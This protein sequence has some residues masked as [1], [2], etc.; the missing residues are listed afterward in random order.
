MDIE[1]ARHNMVEQQI[2]PW[3]V[4]DDKVLKSLIHVKR[5]LFVG[6]D[7]QGMAFADIE[8]PLPNGQHMLTPKT[9]A[10]MIVGLNIQPTDKV[11]E[12]GTGSGYV[13]ALLGRL[14]HHVYSVEIDPEQKTRAAANLQ[15]AH[16]THNV[17]LLE[18]DGLQG[19]LAQ[20]PYQAIFVGGS[21]PAVPGALRQ[22]LAIGGRMVVIVGDQPV[23]RV[24]L[25]ERQG[26]SAFTETELFDTCAERLI[27]AEAL[28]NPHFE[29]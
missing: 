1:L 23:M 29:L 24:K 13:T 6:P 12:V 28:E 11:L 14:G 16:A 5:E 7:Q 21:L 15:A 22:Q 27:D 4:F 9:A 18:G 8:L 3:N 20:S 17:T 26:E 25:I 10:R 2:R 19:F